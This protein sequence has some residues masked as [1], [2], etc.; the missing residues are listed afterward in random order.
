MNLNNF[1]LIPNEEDELRLREQIGDFYKREANLRKNI[2]LHVGLLLCSLK[3]DVKPKLLEFLKNGGLKMPPVKVEIKSLVPIAI[4]YI[5]VSLES[6]E[7]I[8]AHLRL[9]ETVR[10][11]TKGNFNPQYLK[12]NLSKREFEYLEEYGYH[13]IK[14]F[15]HPH[16]TIGNYETEEIRDREMKLAPKIS[17]SITFDRLYLDECEDGSAIPAEILWET[18]L[19]P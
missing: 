11:F 19:G 9:I 15:F 4:D 2:R 8:N 12:H 3:P 5:G 16:L 17:G 10:P 6:P 1:I 13:R 18:K 14:E 7:I